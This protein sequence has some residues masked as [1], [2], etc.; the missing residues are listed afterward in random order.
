L[1]RRAW[2]ATRCRSRKGEWIERKTLI[3]A[4]FCPQPHKELRPSTCPKT[5]S[6]KQVEA[7]VWEKVFR[8]ITNPEYILSQAKDNVAQLQKDYKEMQREELHLQGEIKKLNAERQE[9]ITK[10]RKECMPDEEF[11]PQISALYDKER[12]VQ[13][14]LTTIEREMDDSTKLDLE[15]QINKDVADLQSEMAEL[16]HAN[17]QTSE[18]RHQVFL[19]KKQIVDK[20]LAEARIDENRDIHVK[21]R[22]TY[23]PV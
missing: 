22:T 18:E 19:L 21:L 4:Y 12:K 14:R 23:Q 9:F 1:T 15:E 6:A 10:A 16:I 2:T 13:H 20:V 7:Q 5:V 3:E 8:F 17:P 11:T